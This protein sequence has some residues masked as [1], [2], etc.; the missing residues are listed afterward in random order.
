MTFAQINNNVAEEC[1]KSFTAFYG[2]RLL[3]VD[4]AFI[5]SSTLNEGTSPTGF[6]VVDKCCNDVVASGVKP[7]SK[8]PAAE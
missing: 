1:L 3:S 4:L 5:S 6:L 7:K 8:S 2:Q